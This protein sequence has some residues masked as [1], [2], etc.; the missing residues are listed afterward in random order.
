MKGCCNL[1]VSFCPPVLIF[2][3]VNKK[4]EFRDGL[5]PGLG[6]YMNRKSSFIN[7]DLLNKLFTEHF[8]QHKPLGKVIL[9]SDGHRAH[10]TFLLLLHT[11]VAKSFIHLVVCLTTGPKPL[12][13]R[14]LQYSE[15]QSFLFQMRVSSPN[16]RVI[17]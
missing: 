10:C 8:L 2:K 5:S 6:V 12:P 16:L 7:T 1:Q 13:K 17:Q 11:A 3:G 15:I 9:L 4:Q 14:A